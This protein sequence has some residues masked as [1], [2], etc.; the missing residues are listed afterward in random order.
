MS[1]RFLASAALI[2]TFLVIQPFR[3]YVVSG[4]S[5]STTFASGQIVLGNVRSEQVARGDVVVFR[6]DGET[7]IKRVVYL[8]NDRMEQFF[9]ADEWKAPVN[10]L[11]YRTMATHGFPR[12]NYAIPEGYLYVIGDNRDESVDSREFGPIKLSDVVAVVPGGGSEDY[13][14]F[15]GVHETAQAVALL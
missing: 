14:W 2:G 8:P 11:V 9:V 15:A 12:R 6:R 10:R 13:S 1:P 5:M 4:T 7:M 3:P